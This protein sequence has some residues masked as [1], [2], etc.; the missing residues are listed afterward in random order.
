MRLIISY[1]RSCPG[2]FQCCLSRRDRSARYHD[3]SR[4]VATMDAVDLIATLST[5]LTSTLYEIHSLPLEVAWLQL[6]ADLAG[7][8]PADRL[9]SHFRGKLLYTLRSSDPAASLSGETRER[10]NQERKSRQVRLLSA[11]REFDLV[12]LEPDDL[13]PELLAAIPPQR[14]LISWRGGPCDG[15]Q[16]RSIFDRLAATPAHSYC[17]VPAAAKAGDG[18]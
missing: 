9:R 15:F 14:R 2:S 16:L 11:A 4:E 10:A 13:V 6:R 1:P 18:L 3:S 8:V 5:P 17:L 12:E 7:D